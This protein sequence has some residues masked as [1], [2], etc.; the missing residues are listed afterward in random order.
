MK[1]LIFS[2]LVSTSAFASDIQNENV[3]VVTDSR[4]EEPLNS[5]SSP[6]IVVTKEQ[7][8]LL[9]A[10]NFSD[11]VRLLPGVETYVTGG[12]GQDSKIQIRGGSATDTLILVN[13]IRIN[14]QYDGVVL[15]N[16]I[17]VN[18]IEKIE[19]IRGVK[20]SVYG[21]QASA[22]V[23]NVITRPGYNVDSVNIHAQ[24]GSYKNRLGSVSFEKAIT[25]N[26]Q[27]KIAIGAE[28]EK[29]YNVHPIENV[30]ESDHHGFSNYNFMIDYQHKFENS[31][32]LFSNFS[33]NKTE[34]QFDGSY[35]TYHEYDGNYFQNFSYELGT[36]YNSE[37][38]KTFFTLNFQ[39]TDDYQQINKSPLHEDKAANTP[40]YLKSFNMIWAND[41]SLGDYFTVGAGV[42]YSHNSLGENS[43]SYYTRIEPKNRI[44][45]DVGIFV[46]GNLDY[47]GLLAEISARYDH[48]TQYGGRYTYQGGVG[49]QYDD[50]KLF[51]RHGTS[52][53]APNFMQLYYPYYGNG[54]L[55]PEKSKS[56]EVI[57]EG[58]QSLFDWKISS[59]LNNYSDRIIFDMY[60][61]TYQN[62]SKARIRGVE[63]EVNFDIFSIK[64]FV[65]ADIK[66]PK[67][68]STNEDIPYV[69][70]RTF[71][72][73]ALG[74]ISDFDVSLGFMFFDHRYQNSYTDNL[75]G[76]S[77]WNIGLGYNISENFKVSAKA[78][79]VFNKKYE[80]S[81][82][83][84][85][86][87]A[88]YSIG[89]DLNF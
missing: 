57:L 26:D 10:T 55:N 85:S 60:S 9:Q 14:S 87:E 61:Y 20:A 37:L 62:I 7:I 40:I 35:G 73:T 48:H 2:L 6:T 66:S 71:K 23:I 80:N 8:K 56:F 12:R 16:H 36:K 54:E 83:Y 24:Y 82:G 1:K 19:Y 28:K 76:Y 77:L 3:V 49:Y 45:N 17:P 31:T 4:F 33:W 15:L 65:S 30:N 75:G 68:K 43:K 64:N 18:Q 67:N 44:F 89:F 86:P 81:K 47:S 70:R 38:Y 88:N 11:I 41:F 69:A 79:N 63:F 59:Y 21:S 84:K 46:S 58:K 53:T 29:G 50:Y 51:V 13:G 27:L 5:I 32:E 22:A 42:D 52:F 39:K 25:E 78:N 72:W 74:S 34:A